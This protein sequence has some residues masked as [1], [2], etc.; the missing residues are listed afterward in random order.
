MLGSRGCAAWNG[1]FPRVGLAGCSAPGVAQLGMAF[2]RG[3]DWRD[4][5]ILGLRSLEWR[6]P[7]G[8]IGGML[9]SRGCAAWNGVFPRVGPAGCSDPGGAQ[10]GMAFFRGLDWRDARI[11]GVRSL[12]WRFSAV[13]IG[14]APSPNPNPRPP[15]RPH[16]R[17]PRH[18]PTPRNPPASSPHPSQAYDADSCPLSAESIWAAPTP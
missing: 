6:F 11:P 7:A 8:W 4:A 10:L 18:H 13:W 1:V 14:K 15:T 9:G 3:L 17:L 2:F 16:P 12:E 5:R